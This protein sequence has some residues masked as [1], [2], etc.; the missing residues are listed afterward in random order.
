M[1]YECGKAVMRRL[2]E[3]GFGTRYFVGD[4]IDIGGGYDTLWNYRELFPGMRSCRNWDVEDGDAQEMAGV[5]DE[6]FDFVHSSHC[7]EHMVDP[8]AAIANWFRILRPGGYLI[9]LVPDEDLYEQGVWPST[10]NN[11]HKHSFTLWKFN[12]WNRPVSVNVFE[13]ISRL[14]QLA[15]PIKL[16]RLE[17]SY[18]YALDER[19]DQT[20]LVTGECAVEFVVRKLG[21]PR[22]AE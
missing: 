9:V 22:G 3:P 15:E 1:P 7:L 14:G 17:H 19:I 2:H 6:T 4:G 11:D 12:S 16:A 13:L 21:K 20:Q 18:F 10:W 5:P 8:Y